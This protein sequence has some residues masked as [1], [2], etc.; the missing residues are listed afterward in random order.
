[1]TVSI[2]RKTGKIIHSDGEIDSSVKAFGLAAFIAGLRGREA[3]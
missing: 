3:L 1:M 2:D